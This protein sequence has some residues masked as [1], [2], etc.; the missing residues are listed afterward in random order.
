MSTPADTAHE[1]EG[2]VEPAPEPT[3]DELMAADSSRIT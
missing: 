2:E 1:F 3:Q